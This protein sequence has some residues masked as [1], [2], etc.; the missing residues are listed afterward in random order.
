VQTRSRLISFPFARGAKISLSLFT[1]KG[2]GKGLGLTTSQG[3][4]GDRH[5]CE[6]EVESKTGETRFIVRLPVRQIERNEGAEAIVATPAYMA[7][8]TEQLEEM[9][10]LPPPQT[11]TWVAVGCSAYWLVPKRTL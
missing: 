4:V 7:E 11:P 8:L 5:G 10:S 9:E 2:S 3:I 6:I 1:T